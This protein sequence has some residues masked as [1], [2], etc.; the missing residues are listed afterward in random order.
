MPLGI[1]ADDVLH[2]GTTLKAPI[3]FQGRFWAKPH[4]AALR[5]RQLQNA[6][7]D[8][9]VVPV[10]S[11]SKKRGPLGRW[12]LSYHQRTGG[13]W[14]GLSDWRLCH[15]QGPHDAESRWILYLPQVKTNTSL[16]L[17]FRTDR[18]TLQMEDAKWSCG[19]FG[20]DGV[21]YG[22]AAGSEFNDKENVLGTAAAGLSE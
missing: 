6:F 2:P 16:A 9:F 14:W 5:G 19:I 12:K 11:W 13:M 20:P 21:E 22:G 1:T 8:L 17:G 18:L 4:S 10:C 15:P 3:P 7:D